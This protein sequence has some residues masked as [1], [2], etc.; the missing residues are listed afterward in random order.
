[1]AAWRFATDGT[2]DPGFGSGGMFSHNGAAWEGTGPGNYDRAFKVDVDGS[3]R[4]LASGERIDENGKDD[5]VLWCLTDDGD[6]DIAFGEDSNPADGTPDGFD[7]HDGAASLGTAYSDY[8]YDMEVDS[9]NKIVV[10]GKS[11]DES[12]SSHMVIWKYNAD[13]KLDTSFGNDFNPS[14]GKSDGFV[15]WPETSS[16]QAIAVDASDRIIV[17]GL[18]NSGMATL[19]GTAIWRYNSNGM[20]DSTF[21]ADMDP[22]DGVPDGY[23]VFN[24][25]Q[26]FPTS[27]TV[28]HSG[29]VLAAG[30]M[31]TGSGI[32]MVLLRFTV[33]GD[34]DTT[35]GG[36]T[37]PADGVPD[38]FVIYDH[39]PDI[40]DTEVARAV[41]IDSSGRILVTGGVEVTGTTSVM[42]VWRFNQ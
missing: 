16:T 25:I 41:H 19:Q 29:R 18:I 35:F 34:L 23:T 12:N 4:V 36:D 33:S 17:A 30:F 31:M 42:T 10:G 27:V 38:G 40:T 28:D 2:L 1:M 5:M 37:S 11:D 24:A 39:D 7:A 9:Q 6:L 8:G 32:D 22:S 21:G 15:V 13:G 14:D 3:G 20:L 26:V